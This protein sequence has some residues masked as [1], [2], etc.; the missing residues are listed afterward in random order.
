MFTSSMIFYHFNQYFTQQEN[1]AT[2]C[3]KVYRITVR[4]LKSLRKI[5]THQLFCTT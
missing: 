5:F 1:V 2:T 4:H 3:F